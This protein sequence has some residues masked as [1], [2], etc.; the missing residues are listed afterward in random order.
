MDYAIIDSELIFL[1]LKSSIAK[2]V[3]VGTALP[4]LWDWFKTLRQVS[5]EKQERKEL[6]LEEAKK[7]I[8]ILIK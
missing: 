3:Y 8:P 1:I 5:I 4:I 7:V 6:E 2:G